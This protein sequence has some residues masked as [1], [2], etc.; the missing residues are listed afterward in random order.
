M[1]F[2]ARLFR[3]LVGGAG[4]ALVLIAALRIRITTPEQWSQLALLALVSL[5]ADLFLTIRLTRHRAVS[6]GATFAFTTVLVFG[7]AVAT[8]V[9]VGALLCSQL[10]QRIAGRQQRPSVLY[11]VFNVGQV[12]LCGLLS[13]FAV[14]LFLGQGL[15]EPPSSVLLALVVYAVSYLLINVAITSIATWLRF[16]FAEVREHVW[17]N[18]SLWTAISI[19]LSLPMALLVIS[20]G[21]TIGFVADVVLTFSFLAFLSYIVRINLRYQAANRDLQVLN[22]IS[23]A[24]AT[25]LELDELFPAL[26]ARVRRL[27][28]ADVFVVGL[29]NEDHTTLDVPFMIE[30][31]ERLAPRTL[32]LE[33]TLS[34]RVVHTRQPL[35]EPDFRAAAAQQ[36]FGR[37]DRSPAAILI[38]PLQ[39]SQHV[40]GVLS[41]QSYEP[42]AYTPAQI[43]LLEA[44]GRSAAVAINNAR[45]YEREKEVLRSREEFVSLVAHELKNPLAALLGHSQLLE[46]RTRHADD[47]VRRTV[48]MVLEQGARMNRLVE[49]LLDLS[50]AD[51][52]RLSLHPQPVDLHS[53]VHDVVEQQAL[54]TKQ[55]RIEVQ[56]DSTL[57]RIVG[58]VMRLTQVLTNL[59]SNAI[60]YS[61]NGGTITISARAFAADDPI[62]PRKIR[63]LLNGRR[64]WILVQV[65]DQGM[66]IP[67]DQLE[68][69]FGRFYRANNVTHT[70]ITG[71]GLG[72]SV[73]ESL[74][75]A[76]GGAIWAAS[77]WGEG[78]TFSFTLP[79]PDPTPQAGSS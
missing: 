25:T 31:D 79:V 10:V 42:N 30:A 49:D 28:S 45:L 11:I 57:P 2:S 19:C 39:V 29:L 70:Q 34:E 54:S 17:P 77:T 60:K 14:W 59:L 67:D 66:G 55:H 9:Q 23:R 78:A 53:L 74:V 3:W 12:A 22:E 65:H 76:H 41:V 36:R 50:R 35:Y 37:A 7:A 18:V 4:V 62:W 32:P 5:L 15:Y 52:G 72:L 73:C 58:D 6:L 38:V 75:R 21:S 46:R 71:A 69:I 8:L 40:I 43:G 61:P 13:G 27:M 20:L 51:T 56:M 44:V 16:G 1:P 64:C 48:G 47:K 33:G 68:R 26:D 24:L 63:P